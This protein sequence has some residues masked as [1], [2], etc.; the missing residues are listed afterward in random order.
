MTKTKINGPWPGKG[1]KQARPQFMQI[2]EETYA[3]TDRHSSIRGQ[4]VYTPFIK[5]LMEKPPGEV[6]IQCDSYNAGKAFVHGICR[7]LKQQGLYDTLRPAI[8]RE[9]DISKVWVLK[10]EKAK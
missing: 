8:K 10:Y 2:I 9:G 4:S 6:A 7:Y 3:P 5:V 1:S